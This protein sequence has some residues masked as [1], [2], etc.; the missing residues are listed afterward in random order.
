MFFSN[1]INIPSIL[2]KTCVGSLANSCDPHASKWGHQGISPHSS[3]M[4]I[5]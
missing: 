1:V 3:Y 4:P 5:H 2:R